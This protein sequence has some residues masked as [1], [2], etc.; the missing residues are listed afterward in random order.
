LPPLAPPSADHIY[1]DAALA[2]L[3]F[4]WRTCLIVRELEAEVEALAAG[5]AHREKLKDALNKKERVG[6]AFNVLRLA[7]QRALAERRA[8]AAGAAP[9]AAPPGGEAP[10]DE[11]RVNE[12]LAELLAVMERLDEEIGPL[13]EA[14]GAH[15]NQRWGYLTRT[16]VNDRSQLLRQIEKYADLYSSRVSNFLRYSPFVYFRSP[17]Q[18]MAH[19]RPSADGRVLRGGGNGS[20]APGGGGGT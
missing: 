15:F 5:R 19:D 7:R 8:A 12:A 6:D 9:Q 2:K 13:I 14:D 20:A 3:E 11:A 10:Y 4:N 1:T 18:S 16:G 17:S